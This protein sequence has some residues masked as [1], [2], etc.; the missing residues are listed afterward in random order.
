MRLASLGLQLDRARR[1][2]SPE[3]VHDLRVAARRL[4]YTLDCFRSLLAGRKFRRLRKRAKAVL[5]A[6]GAVRDRD[7]A[8]EIAATVGLARTSEVVKAL[9]C[10]REAAA[11]SLRILIE[12]PRYRRF[13]GKWTERLGLSAWSAGENERH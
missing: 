6:G 12:R 1:D 5:S 13:S 10:Q 9:T 8:L 2:V 7:I 4:Q 3:T 11:R